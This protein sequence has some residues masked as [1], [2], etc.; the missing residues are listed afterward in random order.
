MSINADRDEKQVEGYCDICWE[1]KLMPESFV[2][3]Q[4]CYSCWEE[5]YCN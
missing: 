3:G 5:N 4:M 1:S 2:E